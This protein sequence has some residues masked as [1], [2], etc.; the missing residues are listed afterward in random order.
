MFIIGHY[1][2][3]LRFDPFNYNSLLKTPTSPNLLRFY[4]RKSLTYET[5][6]SVYPLPEGQTY[7]YQ[8]IASTNLKDTNKYL[9]LANYYLS[10]GDL[11]LL[12]KLTSAYLNRFLPNELPKTIGKFLYLTALNLYHSNPDISISFLQ[13]LVYYFPHE[14]HFYIELA[15]AY[16]HHHQTS[17]ALSTV[18]DCLHDS[19]AADHCRNYQSQY[20]SGLPYPGEPDFINY[21]QTNY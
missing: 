21:F 19:I 8:L 11:I 3:S 5:L 12:D 17:P 4:P 15:N 2:L 20:Q 6:L 10:Q 13:K 7:Y 18:K 1:S 16:W 9:D 14:S